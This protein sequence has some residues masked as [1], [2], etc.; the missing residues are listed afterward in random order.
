MTTT[1]FATTSPGTG[2]LFIGSNGVTDG[3]RY[4]RVARYLEQDYGYPTEF[5]QPQTATNIDMINAGLVI[6]SRPFAD[7]HIQMINYAKWLGNKVIIDWDDNFKSIPIHHPAYKTIGPGNPAV[8]KNID[9]I[10]GVADAVV[11]PGLNIAEA[12][13]HPRIVVIPNGWDEENPM[14]YRQKPDSILDRI[15]VG[16]A[17]TVTHREDIKVLVSAMTRVIKDRKNVSFFIGGDFAIPD[18]ITKIDRNKVMFVPG[19]TYEDYPVM[20]SCMDI[21]AA[22]LLDNEFNR[23][24]SAIKLIEAGARG[25]P[26]IASNLP[27]YIEYHDRFGGGTLVEYSELAWE[28]SLLELIDDK[29][30]RNSLGA[31]GKAASIQFAH[32]KSITKQWAELIADIDWIGKK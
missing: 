3:V 9:A 30:K 27:Q 25:I 13:T 12:F 26:Y 29:E 31:E 23:A 4:T 18:S 28:K 21:L 8:A 6:I 16:W 24:K 11:V 17:G 7:D 22:P 5:R 19:M 10:T 1:A 14:W 32:R 2:V 15:I 20:L